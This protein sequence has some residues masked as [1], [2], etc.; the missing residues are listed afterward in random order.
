MVFG[1]EEPHV[2]AVVLDPLRVRKVRTEGTA[3]FTSAGPFLGRVLDGEV[4]LEK[5]EQPTSLPDP[6]RREGC[7]ARDVELVKVTPMTTR[8]RL[9][10]SLEGLRGVVIE[11]YGAG[12]VSHAQLEALRLFSGPVVVTTQVLGD[13]ERLGCYASDRELLELP[14]VVP[15]GRATSVAALVTL[16]WAL[17]SGLGV[18]ELLGRLQGDW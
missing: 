14:Q 4:V 18:A 3:A 17:G 16:S 9:A 10:R 2:D 7:F 6:P 1:S 13:A 8:A 15:A 12:H 5:R 11:G